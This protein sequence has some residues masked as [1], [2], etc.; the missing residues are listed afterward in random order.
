MTY[1]IIMIAV[2]VGLVFAFIRRAIDPGK[3]LEEWV[4][5]KRKRDE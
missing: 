4:E 5:D 1:T 2:V 3:L